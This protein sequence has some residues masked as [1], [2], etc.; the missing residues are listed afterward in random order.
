MYY[1]VYVCIYVCVSACVC[2]KGLI[3]G[4]N[5]RRSSCIP[6]QTKKPLSKQTEDSPTY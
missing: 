3:M 2:F 4:T 5:A 1:P 6:K